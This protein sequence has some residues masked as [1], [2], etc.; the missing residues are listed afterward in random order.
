[1]AIAHDLGSAAA[2]SHRD[3]I[4]VTLAFFDPRYSI[5]LAQTTYC[6]PE[7]R[8]AAAAALRRGSAYEAWR[9]GRLIARGGPRSILPPCYYK[10]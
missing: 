9:D 10:S 3:S 7:W 4:M 6:E 2:I 1:M 8:Y 5:P